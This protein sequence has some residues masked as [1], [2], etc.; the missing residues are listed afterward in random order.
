[1]RK[2]L[3]LLSGVLAIVYC[4]ETFATGALF[5]RPRFS[6]TE[7][8]KM[9]IKSIDVKVDMQEQIAVTHVDQT[10]NN[11]MSSAVEA[12]FVFP[13]P[14]NATISELVYWVNGQKFTANIREASAAISDYN[15]KLR[16]WLDPALLQY[17]GNNLFRLSIVPINANSDVR[18]EITYI[19]KLNYDFGKVNYLY[20]LNT[21]ELSSKALQRVSVSINAN[22][23][24]GY[25]YFSS[26][27]HS[28]ST[29]SKTTKISDNN[30]T[31]LFGDE[32]FFPDKD[33]TIEFETIRKNI[34]FTVLSYKP[35]V[36]DSIGTDSFY[37]IWITPPDSLTANEI[38][39][40]NIVFA[41]DVSSSMDGTRIQQIK[42]AL[43]TFLALLNQGDK[44]NIVTFGT[45]VK[46][47]QPDLI[48]ASA[49]NISAAKDFVFQLYALGLT[50]ID[51]ALQSSLQQSFGDSTSNNIVFFTDGYPTWGDT[52]AANILTHV[53]TNNTKGTRIFSFGVGTEVSRAFLQ[54][55][56]SQNHGFSTFIASNDSIALVINELSQRISKPVL[57]DIS[58]DLGGLPA[59]DEYPKVIND[60]F[61]GSQLTQ[62][63]LYQTGGT[64]IVTVKGKIR[65]KPV[66]FKQT[67]YFTD[68]LG[69]NRV[70][71]RLWAK[72]KIDYLMML[73]DT[74]GETKE[75]KNQVIELSKKFQILSRYTAL[76]VDPTATSIENTNKNISVHEFAVFQNY[77]NPFNPTT[78]ITYSIPSKEKNYHVTV[79]IFNALGEL[80][81]TLTNEFQ[82]S[83]NHSVVWNGKN[84]NNMDVPSGVYLF[85]VQIEGALLV[86]KMI[87]LR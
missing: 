65:Q 21:L 68:T 84:F 23:A 4:N 48:E 36:P 14:E 42:E 41:V 5:A 7:Y 17:L 18:T 33:L 70:I 47:F 61:W 10:F 58:V 44:F 56:A 72:E 49:E 78:T 35:T 46:S 8:K 16:E 1:M 57:T 51:L 6:T 11:E 38:I 45:F 34:E 52:T 75:L 64:Y 31:F 12:I 13:L 2:W 62:L 54:D 60:L 15:Q 79:K 3:L 43:N 80:V 76:Y 71:P 73:I 19:E 9:W 32:N 25:K 81:C 59:W 77:P 53:K 87:L 26:P 39:P 20:K 28:N 24:A 37:T 63:G 85:S 83:G 74:Y 29:S 22:S 86:R 30:Y 82:S 40:K 50:N 66:E 55:L 27:S 69:G 67:V